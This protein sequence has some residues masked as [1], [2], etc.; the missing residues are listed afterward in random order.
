MDIVNTVSPYYR[1]DSKESNFPCS[2][3]QLYHNSTLLS[4]D[5][6]IIDLSFDKFL[7]YADENNTSKAQLVVDRNFYKGEAN[8]ADVP[9]YCVARL[10]KSGDDE[11]SWKY[12]ITYFQLYAY[13]GK[14]GCMPGFDISSHQG[15]IEH[16]TIEVKYT[17][18]KVIRVFT[19]RHASEGKWYDRHELEMIGE[20]VVIYPSRKS[21]AA[22]I[23][24]GI[25][26]RVG[27]C[28]N[29]YHDGK[30]A[31]WKPYSIPVYADGRLFTKEDIIIH[32]TSWAKNYKGEYGTVSPVYNRYWFD[33]G[34]EKPFKR[35]NP[36]WPCWN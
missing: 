30:R 2:M 34:G 18:R 33:H 14:I 22:Y 31:L 35:A 27:F 19:A 11:T 1:F 8:L 9:C 32:G 23:K 6:S 16:V 21:H 28:A 5:D 7:S 36:M 24:K 3:E 17:N 15:D 10:I 4:N 12:V 26:F 20:H 25:Q 13:N 29:D